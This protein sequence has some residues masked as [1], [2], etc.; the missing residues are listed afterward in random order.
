MVKAKYRN[1]KT[2]VFQAEY[3]LYQSVS[4]LFA[5][6]SSESLVIEQLHLYYAELKK[7]KSGGYG[8]KNRIS[9][10]QLDRCL[11]SLVRRDVSGHVHFPS[12][13]V[14]RA[15]VLVRTL[16][17]GLHNFTFPDGVFGFTV[18]LKLSGRG[19]LEGITVADL[20]NPKRNFRVPAKPAGAQY[21]V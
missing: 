11:Q 9:R 8:G 10:E 18:S 14:C 4:A 13:E 17:T 19:R 12:M 20:E 1:P 7:G 15:E 3:A 6:V 5:G 21:C 16:Q 2:K